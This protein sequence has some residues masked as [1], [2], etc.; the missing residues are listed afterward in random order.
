MKTKILLLGM[1]GQVGWELQ[2]SLVLLGEVKACSRQTVDLEDFD[3]LA[4]LVQ[5]YRPNIIVNAVAYTAVDK[6]ESD[7]DLSRTINATVVGLL[8]REIKKLNGWL[9][10][11]STDYVFDGG[12]SGKY[13]EEDNT[14]PLSVYGKTKLQGENLIV[15]SGC[16]YLIFRTSWVYA[17]RGRN[18]IKTILNL[19]KQ[20]DELNV[21]SDQRGVP[22]SA[23]LI[24]DTTAYC[25]CLIKKNNFLSR[26]AIG[27]YNLVPDGQ[28]TWYH[29]A[30]FIISEA[31]RLGYKLRLD[32][33][34]VNPIMTHEYPVPAKRP[35]NSSLDTDKLASTFG[36]NMPDWKL[37]AIRAIEEIVI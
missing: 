28:T 37:H 2:R 19:G 14:N 23:E 12:K 26:D 9:I 16:K 29:F 31:S 1:N 34:N 21:V 11:Y 18:F 17:G 22:T 20:R 33:S 27:V 6:A 13:T 25:L 35:F 15:N 30:K 24:A 8:A 32:C 36:I 7:A 10:H 4:L 3:S 5:D